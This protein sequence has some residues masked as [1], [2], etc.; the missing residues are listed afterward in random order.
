[1]VNK[2]NSKTGY[3]FTCHLS[4]YLWKLLVAARGNKISAF[5]VDPK[6]EYIRTRSLQFVSS[7][8][9]HDQSTD[10]SLW[11]SFL[12]KTRFNVLPC[13]PLSQPGTHP[14]QTPQILITPGSR[15]SVHISA[16]PLFKHNEWKQVVI[17]VVRQCYWIALLC[18]LPPLPLPQFVPGYGPRPAV[19]RQAHQVPLAPVIPAAHHQFTRCLILTESGWIN[20]KNR[21]A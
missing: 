18:A 5:L 17:V 21:R 19:G 12:Y 10:T 6:Y 7:S 8:H 3:N 15:C 14:R 16:L 4:R 2:R 1:M 9:F 20:A 13:Y 11:S